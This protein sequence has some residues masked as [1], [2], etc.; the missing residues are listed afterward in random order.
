MARDRLEQKSYM[1]ANG[2]SIE[3]CQEYIQQ[4]DP[5][6]V[7]ALYSKL[8]L[9]CKQVNIMIA[10]CFSAALGSRHIQREAY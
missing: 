4:F 10:Y 8:D 7:E 3:L 2:A 5:A 1:N 9:K 6:N